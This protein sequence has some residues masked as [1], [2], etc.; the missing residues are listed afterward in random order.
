[1]SQ[2]PGL[3]LN[4]SSTCRY[5]DLAALGC[6]LHCLQLSNINGAEITVTSIADQL[7]ALVTGLPK[8]SQ[9]RIWRQLLEVN[10]KAPIGSRM[11]RGRQQ[12]GNDD[13]PSLPS[14]PYLGSLLHRK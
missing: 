13:F 7:P 8:L 3:H 11:M 4:M 9:Q 10:L 5:N 1:M 6:F 14:S 12:G 2:W